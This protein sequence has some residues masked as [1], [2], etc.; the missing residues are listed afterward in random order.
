MSEIALWS[1]ATT[2]WLPYLAVAELGLSL[3]KVH[4]MASSLVFV[5]TFI[6]KSYSEMTGLYILQ[7]GIFLKAPVALE[8]HCIIMENSNSKV[9][10]WRI[11]STCNLRW[12][13]HSK[14]S[15]TCA[16]W[17]TKC[18]LGFGSPNKWQKTETNIQPQIPY[19]AGI[20][21]HHKVSHATSARNLRGPLPP[22]LKWSESQR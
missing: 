7:L 5:L 22:S 10:S 19:L 1:S 6:D 20:A 3:S 2:E 17:A 12:S 18:T 14:F 9:L 21:H 13:L 4:F 11:S 15:Y 8:L 16:E